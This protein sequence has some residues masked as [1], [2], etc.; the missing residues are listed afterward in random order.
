M[1]VTEDE[2]SL[3]SCSIRERASCAGGNTLLGFEA[4]RGSIL[5]APQETSL[6]GIG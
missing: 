3:S 1:D 6:Y 5:H 4:R 2:G